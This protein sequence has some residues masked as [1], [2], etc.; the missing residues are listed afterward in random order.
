MAR[1]RKSE[2]VS[3]Q[4]READLRKRAATRNFTLQKEGEVWYAE[5]NGTR[6]GPLRTFADIE[7][8]LP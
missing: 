6:F 3:S 8:F 1:P 2:T 4:P 5:I 7:V